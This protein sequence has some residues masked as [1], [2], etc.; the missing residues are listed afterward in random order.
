[1]K[2]YITIENFVITVLVLAIGICCLGANGYF[3]GPPTG[4]VYGKH[5]EPPTKHCS[6][7]YG[8]DR[9]GVIDNDGHVRF[10]RLVTGDKEEMQV[11]VTDG[12]ME[13]SRSQEA[14]AA[15]PVS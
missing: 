14:G 3:D 13:E 11:T 2:K 5:T 10:H 8:K 1:M 7:Q 6:V 12:P 15:A 4:V 9:S